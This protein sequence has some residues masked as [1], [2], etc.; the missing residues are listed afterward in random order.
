MKITMQV[1]LTGILLLSP[2]ITV[3]ENTASISSDRPTYKIMKITGNIVVDGRLSE[4][5]WGP[6]P[7]MPFREIANGSSP[8]LATMTKLVWDSE[9]LYVGMVLDDPDVWSRVGYRDDEW[10]C[11]YVEAVNVHQ[12]MK[13]PEWHRL[14]C[15]IMSLDKFVKVF[16]DPDADGYGYLEFH[17]NPINNVFDAWYDQG[18]V[19]KWDDRD[20]GPHVTW[21]CPGFIS[22]TSIDGTINASHDIDNGWSVEMAIPWTSLAPYVRGSCPPRPGDIWSAHLGR[23]HKERFRSKNIY[24]TWP[25]IG[26]VN[27]HLPSTYGFLLFGE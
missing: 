27:C 12:K 26:V 10:P 15:D 2:T 8:A 5:L 7:V 19:E 21:S 23:V 14:E 20:R 6:V 16:I 4:P 25:V 22:A 11:E 24:W 3:G 1:L 13:N 17:V 9:Y 18:F